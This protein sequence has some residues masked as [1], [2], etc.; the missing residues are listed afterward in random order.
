MGYIKKDITRIL[1]KTALG[2]KYNEQRDHVATKL[3]ETEY[4]LGLVE[5][6]EV[7]G[8]KKYYMNF[9]LTNLNALFCR[10]LNDFAEAETHR[11][12]NCEYEN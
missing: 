8:V 3:V 10:R 6:F 1:S 7:E 9:N 12:F 11:D 5:K 4:M 2:I